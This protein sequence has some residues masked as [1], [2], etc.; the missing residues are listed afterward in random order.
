MNPVTQKYLHIG[1]QK[2]DCWR[3]CLASILECDIE[4]F[5]DPNVITDWPT[6]YTETLVAIEKL[7][8]KYE[9]IPVSLFHEN[10]YCIAIGKSPRSKRK[11]ITHAVVWNNG[12]VHD[13]H[14]DKTGLYDIT[15]FEVFTKI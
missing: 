10:G 4:L 9:S 13:P 8:Y 2:G 15:R 12:I 5:P 6:L 3:A 7:G 1:K 11:R 14:P